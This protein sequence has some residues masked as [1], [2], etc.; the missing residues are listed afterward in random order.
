MLTACI[1]SGRVAGICYAHRGSET[2]TCLQAYSMYYRVVGWQVHAMFVEGVKHPHV[3]RPTT[4]I[5]SGRVELYA[6]FVEGLG[7]PHVY[8]PTAC[9]WSGR[10]AGTC[11]V[12][13][14]SETC[15]CL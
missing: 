9:M 10:V 13:R 3:Y 4:C 8:K 6:M 14:G 12:Y 2:S 5:W 1:W 15:T 7:H 11:Y